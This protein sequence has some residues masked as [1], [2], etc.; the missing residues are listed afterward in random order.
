[1]TSAAAAGRASAGRASAGR[2]SA[3]RA[4]A[5]RGK[6]G[7]GKAEQPQCPLLLEIQ[8]A[9]D[10]AADP[11]GAPAELGHLRPRRGIGHDLQAE[12]EGRGADVVAPLDREPERDRAQVVV[13]ELPVRGRRA[14][15]AGRTAQQRKQP[16]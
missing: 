1:L 10:R 8:R 3:G 5:G 4:E 14:W 15:P 11:P 12:R 9:G 7:R 16:E 13:G 2:A 6:A